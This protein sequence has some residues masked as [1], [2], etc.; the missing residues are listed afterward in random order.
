MTS[1]TTAFAATPPVVVVKVAA[2]VLSVEPAGTGPLRLYE[3]EPAP[4]AALFTAT[5]GE[6]PPAVIAVGVP[7]GV[8][9]S[10]TVQVA[11]PALAA[12]GAAAAPA[13]EELVS[14]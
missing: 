4:S 7:P 12:D 3:P 8:D 10:C 13:L 14:P 1:S 2:C 9:F 11:E 6:P 5:D